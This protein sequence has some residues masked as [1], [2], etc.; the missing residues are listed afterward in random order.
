MVLNGH[1]FI[2]L[3]EADRKFSSSAPWL[4]EQ[5][6]MDAWRARLESVDC[7][8]KTSKPVQGG[9]LVSIEE[10]DPVLR[11]HCRFDQE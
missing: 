4:R 7:G 1:E 11:S 3:F 8:V 5:L 6:K 2:R 9:K 10:Y